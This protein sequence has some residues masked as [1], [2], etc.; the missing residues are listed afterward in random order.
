MICHLLLSLYAQ[1]Q[2]S[3]VCVV[4]SFM[5]SVT[6]SPVFRLPFYFQVLHQ[7]I[8]SVVCCIFTWF[9]CFA[10]SLLWCGW[11]VLVNCWTFYIL[12]YSSSIP[13]SSFLNILRRQ[14]CIYFYNSIVTH[15]DVFYLYYSQRSL[16]PHNENALKTLHT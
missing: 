1:V 14:L 6:T 8:L 3:I 11:W 13:P 10:V 12:L 7:V 2:S 9:P 15:T 16:W 4:F 5:S